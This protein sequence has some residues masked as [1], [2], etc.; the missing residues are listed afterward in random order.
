MVHFVA[1]VQDDMQPAVMTFRDLCDHLVVVRKGSG[2]H[3][4]ARDMLGIPKHL[5]SPH[6]QPECR[7]SL[8]ILAKSNSARGAITDAVTCTRIMAEGGATKGSH[9]LR[10][11]N[12]SIAAF[13]VGFMLR[14]DQP[15]LATWLTETVREITNRQE[16]R[17]AEITALEPYSQYVHRCWIPKP[18]DF[19]PSRSAI[20]RKTERSP[21]RRAD[22]PGSV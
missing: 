22:I 19:G 2:G 3:D 13:R 4:L 11:L 21:A 5:I 18:Y 15:N 7:S 10:V 17:Q 6:E 20:Y 8:D 12:P 14:R 16:F 9:P 1:V